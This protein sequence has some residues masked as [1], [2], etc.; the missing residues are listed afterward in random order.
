MMGVTAPPVSCRDLTVDHG[1]TRALDGVDLDVSPGATVAVLGPSGAGKT[2]LLHAVAGFLP[3]TRGEVH[4]AGRLV[5]SA[6]RLVPPERRSVGVVF[7]HYALWPHLSAL[8]TVAYPFRRRGLSRA[9]SRRRAATLLERMGIAELAGRRPDQL[10]GGQQQ[11][12]G[13]ARALAR[14][15]SVYLFDEPTAHL[16]TAL[17]ATLQEELAERRREQGAAALLATHDA[18]EALGV[19]DMVVLLREGRVVQ[20][21]TPEAIYAEPVDRWA[22][23]LSG[24]ASV[25]ATS[26]EPVD[27]GF[28][29]LRV[30][31]ERVVVPG[32]GAAGGSALVRPDW[33]DLD[34]P[35]SAKVARAWY[36]GPHTDYRL[37]TPVGFVAVRL[38]GPPR[39]AAGEVVGWG[40]RRAWLVR[41]A[42]DC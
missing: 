40:L 3:P 19:A 21:G 5:A 30:G 20:T 15:A 7:Q 2:T 13:I 11:R 17:R 34:G 29:A 9:E 23:L 6:R 33:V 4:V 1:S 37:D 25:L 10:S 42:D 14:E 31:D 8:E 35:L 22:A 12:V 28:V 38:P 26:A 16:D 32:G 18:G 27:R 39:A 24:P 36:R 41:A